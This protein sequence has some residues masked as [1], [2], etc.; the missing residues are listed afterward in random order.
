MTDK[1]WELMIKR[2][3]KAGFK[4]FELMK[5]VEG[6]YVKR[7]GHNPSDVDDDWWI[8]TVHYCIGEI[9]IERIKESAKT[10]SNNR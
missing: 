2:C 4:Y 5:I 1:E 7:Y 9:N 10:R 3:Q 6:E 8:D